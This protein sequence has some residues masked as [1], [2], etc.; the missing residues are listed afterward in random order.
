MQRYLYASF[1]REIPSTS[2]DCWEGG[3]AGFI[4]AREESWIIMAK[5]SST[6]GTSAGRFGAR[7]G[8]VARKRVGDIE[9]MMR[10]DHRCPECDEPAV[11]RQGTGIW[12]CSQCG[13]RFAGGTFVPETPA[14]ME[15]ERSIKTAL[16]E[17]EADEVE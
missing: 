8:R 7:Y 15:A 2:V 3:V 13:H 1:A 17:A 6:T 12:E 10:Q 5:K 4:L 9:R 11:D 14:G 16:E